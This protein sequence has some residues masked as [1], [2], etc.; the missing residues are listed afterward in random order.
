[1]FVT[2]HIQGGLGNQLFQLAF[3]ECFS[4]RTNIPG[5]INTTQ[6]P[7]TVHSKENYFESIFKNWISS[8][9]TE[10]IQ[11][12]I[13]EENPDLNPKLNLNTMYVG[14][15]QD[16][17]YT[18]RIRDTFTPKLVFDTQ[19]LTKYPDIHTKFF[20]HVRGGDYLEQGKELHNIDLTEY[21]KKCLKLC[22]NEEF[23]VFTNDNKYT[24]NLFGTK[25]PIISESEVD[26][27]YL[28]SQCKGCICANSSF[29]WWGSYLNPRRPIYMPS[30]WF[31]DPSVQGNY[32]FNGVTVVDINV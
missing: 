13:K 16:F 3:L 30:K 10:Q 21:Y 5:K 12:V 22:P 7:G 27:L 11:Y 15:F 9:T 14:Y 8:Y 4:K 17:K 6:S 2:V 26:T 1:M 28:M 20:I 32:Y 18:D 19:I 29:S 23:V 25:F 31:N 24:N